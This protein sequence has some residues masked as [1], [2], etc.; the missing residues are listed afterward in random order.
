MR[1]WQLLNNDPSDLR[2]RKTSDTRLWL[3]DRGIMTE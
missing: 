3:N 1:V 2:T